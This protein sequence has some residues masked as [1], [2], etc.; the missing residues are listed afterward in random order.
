[1]SHKRARS[2][3]A[4]RMRHTG[5]VSSDTRHPPA[6]FSFSISKGEIGKIPQWF[7]LRREREREG[8]SCPFSSSFDTFVTNENLSLNNRK[9][10]RMDVCGLCRAH[11]GFVYSRGPAFGDSLP[12]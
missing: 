10:N 7:T 4:I 9:K 11:G 1:M 12:I 6:S 8:C 3:A 2:M 5:P